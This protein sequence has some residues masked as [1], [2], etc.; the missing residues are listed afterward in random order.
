MPALSPSK[1]QSSPSPYP[2]QPDP[3]PVSVRS[4][5]DPNLSPVHP[6]SQPHLAP[7]HAC[8]PC[9]HPVPPLQ[10]N[11]GTRTGAAGTMTTAST[12]ST[13]SPPAMG[14]A[15]CAGTPS[16]TATV[17]AGERPSTRLCPAASLHPGGGG[18]KPLWQPPPAPPHP[19]SAPRQVEGVPAAG[20][21]H[22]LAGGGP[23]LLQRHP[24]ALLRVRL[25]G[26]VRGALPLRLVSAPRR[27]DRHPSPAPPGLASPRSLQVQGVQHGGHRGAQGAGAV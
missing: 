13:P 25:Q 20:E 4:N 23:G 11:T 2:S 10:G 5:S 19:S 12:S 8:G 27:G 1:C 17:T 7:A 24:G 16:A 9:L 14:T 3:S 22:G 6:R 26:G 21:R 15:T 18:P